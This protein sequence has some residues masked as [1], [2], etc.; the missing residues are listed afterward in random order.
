MAQQGAW[1]VKCD[2]RFEV[3]GD[4]GKDNPDMQWDY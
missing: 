4:F 3:Y 1:Q 2:G